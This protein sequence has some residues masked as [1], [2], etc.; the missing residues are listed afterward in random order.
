MARWRINEW[1]VRLV[2]KVVSK[3]AEVMASKDSGLHLSKDQS[4]WQFVHNFS[5]GKLMATV[6][7]KAPTLL[8]VLTAVAVAGTVIDRIGK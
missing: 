1:A 3:E 5:F 4:N 6:Q 8:K 7:N 2:E